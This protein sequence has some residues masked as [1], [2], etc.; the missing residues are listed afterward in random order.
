M[1]TLNQYLNDVSV[2]SLTRS[3]ISDLDPTSTKSRRNYEP[4]MFENERLKEK[5]SPGPIRIEGEESQHF[6][7]SP[8]KTVNKY[9]QTIN[10]IFTA[11][12][13]R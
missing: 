12:K 1:S 10:K 9:E 4:K 11:S 2:E 3:R 6:T 13:L 5:L 8:S 7:R